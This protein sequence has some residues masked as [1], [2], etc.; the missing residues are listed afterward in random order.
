MQVQLAL[1]LLNLHANGG[2]LIEKKINIE[3]SHYLYLTRREMHC[4]AVLN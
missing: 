2:Y 4:L 3:Y 1:F